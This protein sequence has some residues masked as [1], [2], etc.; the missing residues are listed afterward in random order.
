MKLQH[1]FEVKNELGFDEMY[2]REKDPIIFAGADLIVN[3]KYITSFKEFPKKLG[4]VANICMNHTKLKNLEGFPE[5]VNVNDSTHCDLTIQHGPLTSLTG[6]PK[7]CRRLYLRNLPLLT[8]LEGCPAI[9]HDII[10]VGCA[11]MKDL[12]GLS[13]Q[14]RLVEV[15]ISYSGI[16][17]FEGIPKSL[18]YLSVADCANMT[19]FDGFPD[20]LHRLDLTLLARLFNYSARKVSRSSFDK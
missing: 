6:G 4:A 3:E 12:K 5:F 14:T 16:T 8:S 20:R 10:V 18:H 13:T 15:E 11:N 1:L 2:T 17:S 7:Y 19:S 9:W